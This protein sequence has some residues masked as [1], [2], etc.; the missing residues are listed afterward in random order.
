MKFE[1][2]Y[3]ITDFIGKGAFGQVSKCVNLQTREVFAVKEID[4]S[5]SEEDK[6]KAQNEAKICGLLD[7]PSIVHLEDVFFTPR[8]MLLVL[9]YLP[10]GDLFDG[11]VTRTQFSEK[12][13]C[14][15]VRQVLKA[16]RYLTRKGIIHRDLKPENLLLSERPSDH[17]PPIIKLTDFGIAKQLKGNGSPLYLAPE[18][19]LEE[20]L[21]YAVDI[22]ACGVILYLL[23]VG[24]PP[25]WNEQTEFLLLSILQSNY[26]FPSPYW[27]TVSEPAKDLIRKMLVVDPR[28]RITAVEALKH[29]WVSGSDDIPGLRLN[30][31]STLVR[32]TA[33]NARRKLRGVVLGLIA[34]KR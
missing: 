17:R 34:R 26:T 13:A 22:W 24:Y 11:V 31:Q 9:E 32:L 1:D 30:R 27:D 25:F 10:G 28:D 3:E 23:L 18:T 2:V 19:I 15:C 21:T 4:F 6:K 16:L 33:F 20:G 29:E 7:H 5:G 14:A 8:R 12:D